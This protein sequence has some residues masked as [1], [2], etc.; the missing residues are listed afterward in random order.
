VIPLAE[1]GTD[2]ERADAWTREAADSANRT[3]RNLTGIR[4]TPMG[5]PDGAGYIAIQLDGAW[6]RAPYLHNG[7]VP[8]LRALLEPP[9]RR[10]ASF[11]RGYDVLDRINGGFISRRCGSMTPG[12]PAST[13]TGQWGCM[14]DDRG[15]LFDTGERGNGNGGH[16]YGVDLSESDKRALVEYL[17]TF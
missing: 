10:P 5:K 17:K 14:P 11:Y 2:P 4:R 16:T 15:W 7:S 9:D 12:A 8:T 13:E 6:L 1:I 3:V